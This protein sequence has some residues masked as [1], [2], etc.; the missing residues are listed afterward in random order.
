MSDDDSFD[1]LLPWQ[2]QQRQIEHIDTDDNHDEPDG[3]DYDSDDCSSTASMEVCFMTMSTTSLA[4]LA[5]T[6]TVFALTRSHK[7]PILMMENPFHL[8]P[9]SYQLSNALI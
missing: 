3:R 5:V 2:S 4:M 8:W 1:E 9:R 7:K 6:R